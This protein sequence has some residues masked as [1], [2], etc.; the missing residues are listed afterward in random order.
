MKHCQILSMMSKAAVKKV[1]IIVL[2]GIVALLC[3][4]CNKPNTGD[5]NAAENNTAEYSSTAAETTVE[6]T[7]EPPQLSDDCDKVLAAGY[8]KDDNYYELVA[9]ETEN[10][11]GTKIEIGVIKN[12]KWS[13]PLTTDSPFIGKEGL[14][15]RYNGNSNVTGSIYDEEFAVFYYI[16]AGCFC[17]N[18]DIWNGNNG[19]VY[20]SREND[21]Y[22]PVIEITQTER[23]VNNDGQILLERSV[24][25]NYK[26]LNTETMKAAII[27]LKKGYVNGIDH[28]FPYSEGLF[29][30]MKNCDIETNGFYNAEGKK[31]IDLSKYK[32]ASKT[33]ENYRTVQG[34]VIKG[35][36]C[37]FEITNDQGTDYTITINKKGEVVDSYPSNN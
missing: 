33:F 37:T 17:Y 8:D 36:K 4:S 28:A 22:K 5:N 23:I 13:I 29:A 16:G 35:G 34:L 27:M 21:D 6:E 7:T 20:L 9:N 26:L 14:L 1:L 30:V 2:C 32:L 19:K 11:D 12:N 10:Y 24:E 25:N 15:S 18:N 31:V 3:A